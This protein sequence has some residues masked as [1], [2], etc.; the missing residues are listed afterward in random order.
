MANLDTVKR[1]AQA[2]EIVSVEDYLKKNHALLKSA[3]AN[4]I[5]PERFLALAMMIVKTP[6]LTGCDQQ[7]LVAA[8]VGTVQ[9]GLTPGPIGHVYYVPFFNSR[10]NVREV[11]L[12]I[13][14][15]GL[16][17]LINRSGD[18]SVLSAEVVYEQ[19]QFQYE[20][21][22]NPI[23]RHIPAAEKRGKRMG[24]YCIAK[25]M[26]AQEKVF[27]YLSFEEVEKVKKV[28]MDRVK[29]DKKKFSP[30]TCWE[31]DMWRKTAVKRIAKLLPLSVETQKKISADETV[32]RQITPDM[33][34]APD[35]A[36]WGQPIDVP[37]TTTEPPAGAPLE[38]TWKCGDCSINIPLEQ[39]DKT[40]ASHKVGLCVACVKTHT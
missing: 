38:G 17:E 37:A 25:N 5:T 35:E 16:A 27:I 18:A 31:D 20:H 32:K 39:Y 22:L 30:W 15:K 3:L 8:I 14:Y 28:A 4:T 7:S 13:G 11:T 9:I 34:L 33:S 10:K 24:V 29:E 23:L 26:I 40:L 36:A 19:D 2:T 1:Q 21:G 12:I 6:A